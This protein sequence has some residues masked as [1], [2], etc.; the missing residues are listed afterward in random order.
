MAQKSGRL[1]GRPSALFG[2]EKQLCLYQVYIKASMNGSSKG[3]QG[4]FLYFVPVVRR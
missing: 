3:W 4:C 1:K 2:K